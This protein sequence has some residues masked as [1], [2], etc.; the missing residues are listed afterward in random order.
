VAQDHL[1][2]LSVSVRIGDHADDD[3]SDLGANDVGS[4]L[5]W[6]WRLTFNPR[7]AALVT[8]PELNRAEIWPSRGHIKA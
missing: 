4:V 7:S 3:G 6:S 1:A 2:S 8:S 5:G